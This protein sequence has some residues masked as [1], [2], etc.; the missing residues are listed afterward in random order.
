MAFTMFN[1]VSLTMIAM[2]MTGRLGGFAQNNS[3]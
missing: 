1:Y 3:K 2:A